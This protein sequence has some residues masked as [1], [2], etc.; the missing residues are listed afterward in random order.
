[1][2]Y[3]PLQ[4]FCIRFLDTVLFL[5][6]VAGH[7]KIFLDGRPK[8]STASRTVMINGKPVRFQDVTQE[9]RHNL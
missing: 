2:I 1:M 4:E 9:P 8:A 6:I 3:P 5:V 7:I